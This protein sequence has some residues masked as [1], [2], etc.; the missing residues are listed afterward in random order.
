MLPEKRYCRLPKGDTICLHP[1]NPNTSSTIAI[2]HVR[3]KHSEGHGHYTSISRETEGVSGGKGRKAKA[4]DVPRNNGATFG[5]PSHWGY[6]A[7][8]PQ[9]YCIFLLTA[10]SLQYWHNTQVPPVPG[11]RRVFKMVE[12]FCA[13]A[14]PT[15]RLPK[16]HRSFTHTSSASPTRWF[17]SENDINSILSGPASSP[18]PEARVNSKQSSTFSWL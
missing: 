11:S 4:V 6:G 12:R 18:S 2:R 1:L 14:P 9:T 17:S 7:E 13:T 15:R 8:I 3:R 16:I 10:V 5:P